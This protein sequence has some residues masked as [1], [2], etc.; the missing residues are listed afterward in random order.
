MSHYAKIIN[1]NNTLIVDQVIVAE[2]D[3]IDTLSG[4]WIQTSYNTFGGVHYGPDKK[5]DDGVALRKN[6]AGVGSIY[7]RELDAFYSPCY[8]FGWKLNPETCL[9]EPPF[10]K[11]EDGQDYT[12]NNDLKNWILIE[13][14]NV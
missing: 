14:R 12:W 1:I 11:P 4:E 5:P 3:F 10:D 9:W 6:Y 2:Q 7:N 13:K 8:Y